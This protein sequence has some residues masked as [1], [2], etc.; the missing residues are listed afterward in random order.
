MRVRIAGIAIGVLMLT[1]LPAWS[2]QTPSRPA[3][4]PL[5][6][7]PPTA[8]AVNPPRPGTGPSGQNG[9][10]F[11]GGAQQNS[12]VPHST[13]GYGALNTQPIPPGHALGA[14]KLQ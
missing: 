11:V 9:I 14:T 4:A 5:P 10:I 7:K 1:A 2:Q 8:T 6:Q 3:K 13:T 12:A